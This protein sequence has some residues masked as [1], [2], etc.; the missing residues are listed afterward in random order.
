MNDGEPAPARF[1]ILEPFI[2]ALA[3]E[4]S[5][6]MGAPP[7]RLVGDKEVFVFK[8]NQVHVEEEFVSDAKGRKSDFARG[9]FVQ[10]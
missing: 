2:Q 9:A 4:G 6:G 10:G 1:A 5:G 3:G 7:G 8:N